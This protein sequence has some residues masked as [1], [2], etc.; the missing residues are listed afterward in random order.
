[1]KKVYLGLLL[2][3]ALFGINA[4]N[5]TVTLN[6]GTVNFKGYVLQSSCTI[7]YDGAN[8]QTVYLPV[9][10]ASDWGL[11]DTSNKTKAFSIKLK[12]CANDGDLK[13]FTE[14]DVYRKI[15]WDV[16]S[17]M[18][19]A[20]NGIGPLNLIRNTG[21]AINV[22]IYLKDTD[23]ATNPSGAVTASNT[24]FRASVADSDTYNFE[25]G[26]SKTASL[27]P[28]GSGS[29]SGSATFNVIYE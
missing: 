28:P 17:G 20:K 13:N 19:A 11:T 18:W 21:S 5:A 4:A 26:Y 8:G 10:Q 25:A 29:V 2:S 12:D 9:T 16:N 7:S 22:S 27:L 24:N 3:T 14:P 15:S 23:T 6:G 1:M